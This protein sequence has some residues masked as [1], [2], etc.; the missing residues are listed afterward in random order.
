[1]SGMVDVCA[2][3]CVCLDVFSTGCGVWQTR[4][5]ITFIGGV[6]CGEFIFSEFLP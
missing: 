4:T 3:E 1:M 5:Y 6:V 2:G